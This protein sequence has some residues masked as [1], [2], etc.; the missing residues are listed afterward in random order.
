MTHRRLDEVFPSFCSLTW[1]AADFHFDEDNSTA[2]DILTF[3]GIEYMNISIE[4]IVE[5]RTRP[6]QSQKPIFDVSYDDLVAQPI[7]TVRRIYTHFD[8][9]WSSEFEE[10]MNIWLHN[11]PQGK[12]G[13]HTY[14]LTKYGLKNE[15]IETRYADYIH[16]FLR[17]AINVSE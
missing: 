12:Q 8:L 3:R 10:A 7:D 6:H 13:R 17:P 16:L 15:D 2:R 11:N 4:R 9:Q 5:F 1:A 14:S